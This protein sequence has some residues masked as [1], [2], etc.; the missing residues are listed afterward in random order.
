MIRRRPQ[1]E[2]HIYSWMSDMIPYY[3]PLERSDLSWNLDA[4]PP[5]IHD[6]ESEL[7]RSWVNVT[8]NLDRM[9]RYVL[10]GKST[11]RSAQN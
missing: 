1:M 9:E 10:A 5:A 3:Y 11:R 2:R 7:M 8:I 6:N 4:I